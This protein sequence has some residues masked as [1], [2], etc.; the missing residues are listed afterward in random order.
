ME[1]TLH[2][3]LC[4]QSTLLSTV[5]SR[6]I[7]L[8]RKQKEHIYVEQEYIPVGCV[9]ATRRPYAGVCFPGGCLLWGVSARRRGSAPGGWG[10]SALGGVCSW[11][12]CS[13]W[14]VVS[15]HALRQTP[16]CEQNDKQV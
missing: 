2:P 16:P 10:V 7:R 5:S 9:P 14:G 15:Q 13:Q 8:F 11:G 3:C 1:Y 4:Y 12:V 6:D